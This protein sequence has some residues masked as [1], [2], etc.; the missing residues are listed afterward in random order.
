MWFDS[1]LMD[2]LLF[3]N[4]RVF[5]MDNNSNASSRNIILQCTI[6]CTFTDSS[7]SGKRERREREREELPDS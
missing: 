2:E 1:L 3:L 5:K 6:A 7:V 4:L